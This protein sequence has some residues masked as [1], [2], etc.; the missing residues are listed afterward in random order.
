MIEFQLTVYMCSYCTRVHNAAHDCVRHELEEHSTPSTPK[1]LEPSTSSTLPLFTIVDDDVKLDMEDSD[2]QLRQSGHLHQ[3][4]EN[5]LPMETTT[6]EI[7]EEP[8]AST[9]S[10]R[11]AVAPKDSHVPSHSENRSLKS[12]E[13]TTKLKKRH[14]KRENSEISS[15]HV[16]SRSRQIKTCPICGKVSE[17]E[18]FGKK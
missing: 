6:D 13:M 10:G 11:V 2:F 18:F 15:N 12:V 9:V 1:T 3:V 14:E 5:D 8:H 7:I 4:I 17:D 16:M